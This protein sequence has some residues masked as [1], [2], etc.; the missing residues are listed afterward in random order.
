MKA[1]ILVGGYGTRLRPLTL[2]VPKPLVEFANIPMVEHQIAALEAVGVVQVILAVGYDNERMREA[3]KVF[4]QKYKLDVVI[5]RETT[6]LGTAGPI[7][8]AEEHLSD[9]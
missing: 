2:S 6:P 8:L 3:V 5:S 4:N 7:K 9:C 1:L